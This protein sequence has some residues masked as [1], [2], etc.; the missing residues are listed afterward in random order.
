MNMHRKSRSAAMLTAPPSPCVKSPLLSGA[1][2]LL[3]AAAAAAD[4]VAVNITNDGSEDIVV[5]VYDLTIGRD[6]VVLAHARMTGFTTIPLSV[7]ADAS[8][9][10]NLSWTAVT[11]DPDDHKCG[12]AERTGLRDSASVTVHADSTCPST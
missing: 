3:G 6:A 1:L 11:V 8:G 2:L 9:M 12:H 7:T 5:T 4:G 10:A